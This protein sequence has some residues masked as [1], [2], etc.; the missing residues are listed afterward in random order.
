MKKCFS[1]VIALIVA[2][3]LLTSC[4]SLT[5]YSINEQDI[6]KS[7][8]KAQQFQNQIGVAGLIDAHIT[9]TELSTQIGRKE[10]DYVTLSGI[11][12]M[13]VTSLLG[14]QHAEMKL[15]MKARTLF[16]Q[17]QGA[18]FLK[19]M[20]I[21][22]VQIYPEKMQ[23]VLKTLIPYLNPS[24]KS[25]FNQQP[26]YVLHAD[27]RRLEFLVKKFAKHLEVKPGELIIHFTD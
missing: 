1:R 10:L 12:K 18:I 25:H 16:N 23:P 9:L 3:L 20:Q 8:G 14:S 24:L 19:N 27:R 26:I 13:G 6:D 22:D 17:Q 7:L 15:T 4:N 2:G 21:T 11:A 5:Q